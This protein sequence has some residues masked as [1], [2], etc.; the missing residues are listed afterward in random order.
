MKVLHLGH[1]TVFLPPFI[2]RM[3]SECFNKN[4]HIFFLD[5][6]IASEFIKESK[7]V[8]LFN[9]GFFRNILLLLK[10]VFTIIKADKIVLHGLFCPKFIL[11]IF[12][13]PTILR[14][15]YWVIWG[16][17][18]YGYKY[19]KGWKQKIRYFFIARIAKKIA[20]IITYIKGDYEN[21]L[22]WFGSKAEYHEC[23][24]YESNLYND[25]FLPDRDNNKFNI[26]VGN[27][28]DPMNFHTDIFLKIKKYKNKNIKIY[29]PLSYGDEKYGR[30]IIKEGEM[31]FGEKINFITDHMPF[32]DYLK[33]LSR[34]DFVLFNHP[35]QMAMGNTITLLGLG[36]K[37]YMR[38]DVTQWKL[39]KDLG[40]TV[41]D[42]KEFDL[43]DIKNS[44]LEENKNRVKNYFSERM[45]VKQLHE[46]FH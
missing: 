5:V 36:K 12:L 16:A 30:K 35:Y 45:Y 41:Y 20:H 26:L 8:K 21:A 31:L 2:K 3:E 27:S 11:V 10:L 22:D 23:L 29:V 28:A 14:K 7:S 37:V 13:M 24:M 17:D 38:S 18:L 1:A 39:F 42:I 46:I 25:I 19:S 43:N 15:S 40:I 44:Q 9:K 4:Q 33:L 34:I 6:S 32:P